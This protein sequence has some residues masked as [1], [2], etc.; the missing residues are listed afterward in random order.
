[1]VIMVP[2]CVGIDLVVLENNSVPGG[3]TSEELWERLD[4]HAKISA[5]PY[6]AKKRGSRSLSLRLKFALLKP[7]S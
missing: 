1:M 6:W 7:A 5:C 2:C 3:L 4:K